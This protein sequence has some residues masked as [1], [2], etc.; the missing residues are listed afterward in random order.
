MPRLRKLWEARKEFTHRE[1]IGAFERKNNNYGIR[2]L[3]LSE[4][5]IRGGP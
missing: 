4:P 1:Q 2:R 5:Q 3:E